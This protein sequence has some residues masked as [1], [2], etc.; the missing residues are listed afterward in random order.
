ME[1]LA[2]SNSPHVPVKLPNA[3]DDRR[4]TEAP[5]PG[6]PIT[7]PHSRKAA[8]EDGSNRRRGGGRFRGAPRSGQSTNASVLHCGT[9]LNVVR[10][11]AALDGA[12]ALTSRR[13]G[14]T[15][16]LH[17]K[18]G[19]GQKHVDLLALILLAAMVSV[20]GVGNPLPR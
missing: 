5:A 10:G 3:G 8:D 1:V 6:A 15:M 20:V 9:R 18:D 2:L 11:T 16:R 4:G 14:E 12:S 19:Y 13:G 17:I 7:L